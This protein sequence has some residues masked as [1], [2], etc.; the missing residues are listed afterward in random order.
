M[1]RRDTAEPT[2]TGQ[3]AGERIRDHVQQNARGASGEGH[4]GVAFADEPGE[5]ASEEPRRT[6]ETGGPQGWVPRGRRIG[7]ERLRSPL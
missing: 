5:V 6:P 4:E 3:H 7:L 2:S 1:T